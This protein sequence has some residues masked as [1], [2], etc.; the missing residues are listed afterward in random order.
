[1]N[2]WRSNKIRTQQKH[3]VVPIITFFWLPAARVRVRGGSPFSQLQQYD[4]DNPPFVKQQK[5]SRSLA[6]TMKRIKQTNSKN[7]NL[8][9][10]WPNS[11]RNRCGIWQGMVNPEINT[12]KRIMVRE[13]IRSRSRN[14]KLK[15]FL[16][17][18]FIINTGHQL[19]IEARNLTLKPSHYSRF[20][21]RNC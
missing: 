1:M 16:N 5:R 2:I 8:C 20:F 11:W 17:M 9:N 6:R 19:K 15:I 21:D 14:S 3:H 18:L 4:K 10:R 12:I 13:R 7:I